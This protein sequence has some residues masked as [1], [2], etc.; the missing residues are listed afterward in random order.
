M[1]KNVPSARSG[2]ICAAIKVT[3]PQCQLEP[4]RKHLSDLVDFLRS[5]A[6]RGLTGAIACRQNLRGQFSRSVM[7]R[8]AAAF[9]SKHRPVGANHRHIKRAARA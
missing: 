6:E 8:P 4:A 2:R 3:V 5:V 9:F 1:S 7:A